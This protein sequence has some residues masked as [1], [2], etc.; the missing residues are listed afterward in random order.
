MWFAIT[1]ERLSKSLQDGSGRLQDDSKSSP[2][3]IFEAPSC[4]QELCGGASQASNCCPATSSLWPASGLGGMREA[5]TI[6][7]VGQMLP[8]AFGKTHP[9]RPW[10]LQIAATW[11]PELPRRSREASE[12]PPGRLQKAPRRLREPSR[13]LQE[14]SRS[15]PAASKKLL[16][17]LQ[18]PPRGPK[19]PPRRF[20]MPPRALKSISHELF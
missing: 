16:R 1:P 2:E 10:A 3:E 15:H 6:Q 19:T 17:A 13:R 18:L 20:N 7:Q 4:L 9:K 11:P 5:L 8:R 12:T 14:A